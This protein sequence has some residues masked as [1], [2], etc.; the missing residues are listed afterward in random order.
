MLNFIK[1]KLLFFVKAQKQAKALALRTVK[2]AELS[3][4]TGSSAEAPQITIK[5]SSKEQG[6]TKYDITIANN[7]YNVLD[8]LDLEMAE[9]GKSHSKSKNDKSKSKDEQ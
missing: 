3:D 4:F 1:R 2:N 6:K 5:T 9:N 7:E 8:D